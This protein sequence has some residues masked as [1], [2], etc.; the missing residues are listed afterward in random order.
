MKTWLSVLMIFFG[1]F[2]V[3]ACASTGEDVPSLSPT[4][5][6]ETEN[7]IL[8][9]EAL[10]MAFTECLR[11][12]GLEVADPRVDSDGKIEFP[13]IIDEKGV[14]KEA[15]WEA[16][17]SILDRITYEE[18]I[19]DKTEELEYYLEL[20]ACLR[21]EGVE[22]A[23]PTAETLDSWMGDFKTETDFDDPDTQAAFESCTDGEFGTGEGK[24][25]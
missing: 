15:W 20:A 24:E 9:N 11:S 18:E 1:T 8:T 22:V 3:A 14:S 5:T 16:C 7:E 2:G 10:M 25:K 19:E 12:E 23:D 4:P 17:G 13:E 21:E 6:S